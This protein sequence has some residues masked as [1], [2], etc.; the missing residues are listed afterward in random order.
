M[1]EDSYSER[2]E[3]ATPKRR[4]EARKKGQIAKSREIPSVLILLGGASTLYFL[5]SFL[6]GQISILMVRYLGQAATLTLQPANLQALNVDLVRSTLILLTPIFGTVLILS[7]AGHLVQSGVSFSLD[8]LKLDWS[9]VGPSRGLR[10]V[11]SKQS[12]VELAKAFFKIFVIGAAVWSVIKGEGA[13]VLLLSDQGAGETFRYACSIAW[14]LLLKT[15]V[16]LL[17]LASLD[18][19]F[20]RWSFEKSL[21]MTK[22]E[23]KEESRMMEGDPLIKSRIRSIQR[24]MARKRMMA[25]VPKADVIITNP[26]HLAVALAYRTKEMDAPKVVAK[27]AGE[28]AERIKEIGRSHLIPIIENKPLAQVLYKT[29]DLGQAIPP[30]LYQVVA[31]ILAYVY[32]LKNRTVSYE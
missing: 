32:R 18:Y 5:G 19:F 31:D 16:I 6:Y 28:I 1:A 14:K 30:T 22:E 2:T 27:G 4:E 13:Q 20:Q 24:Q 8:V 29:V 11:F 23:V 25:E 7:V 21:R 10:Q 26:T 15:G 17:A 9:K 3:Q 12:L